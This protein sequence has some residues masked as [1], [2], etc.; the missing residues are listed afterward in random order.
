MTLYW[1]NSNYKALTTWTKIYA[2]KIF[3]KTE[4]E[5]LKLNIIGYSHHIELENKAKSGFTEVLASQVPMS[6]LDK[7]TEFELV[8]NL[9]LKGSNWNLWTTDFKLTE[10][11]DFLRNPN[12]LFYNFDSTQDCWTI[13]NWE[14][15]K[16]AEVRFKTLHAYPE[17]GLN[18][19]SKSHYLIK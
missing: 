13:I 8:P 3:Q 4:T 11:D 7:S 17:Y 19:W 6:I 10:I 2:S 12:C 16:N 1:Y 18:L 15:T 9:D 5:G 14:F